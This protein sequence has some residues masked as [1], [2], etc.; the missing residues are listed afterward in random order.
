M[1]LAI[2]MCMC[3]FYPSIVIN[4]PALYESFNASGNEESMII[5]GGLTTNQEVLN[6]AYQLNL[7][8]LNWRKV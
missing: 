7:G 2:L 6:N 1:Q 3:I 4:V 5:F 8:T